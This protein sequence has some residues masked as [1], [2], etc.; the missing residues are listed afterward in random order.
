MSGRHQGDART[1][2]NQAQF[3]AVECWLLATTKSQTRPILT[4]YSQWKSIVCRRCRSSLWRVI[5]VV[6]R[7]KW[8]I[9]SSLLLYSRFLTS[10]L[11][12][13]IP[14]CPQFP[15]WV[16]YSHHTFAKSCSILN[17][18]PSSCWFTSYSAFN[19]SMQSLSCLKT[20][21]LDRCFI[22]QLESAFACLRL[23]SWELPH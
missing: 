18:S 8:T 14:V 12:V 22:C 21:P 6:R 2:S 23:L 16:Q 15:V 11:C 17:S 20:W 4:T 5:H 10:F 19:N 7:C 13:S 1:R 9:I 3:A